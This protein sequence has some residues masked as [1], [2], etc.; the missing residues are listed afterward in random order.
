VHNVFGRRLVAIVAL[1]VLVLGAYAV[2]KFNVAKGLSWSVSFSTDASLI[3]AI[4]LAAIVPARKMVSWARGA[5]PLSGTTLDQAR[6]DLARTLASSWAEEE[7]LRRINDPWPLPVR[8][9]GPEA[10]QFSEI[11]QFFIGAASR[12]LVILGEAGAGKTALAIKLVLE[13]L[14]T[15]EAGDPVPVLLA[16]ATWTDSVAMT[17]W[18]ARQLAFDHPGLAVTIRTGIGETVSLAHSLASEVLPVID[19]LDELPE[20]RRAQVI[21]EIN[22][23]G[24][25]RSVVLTSRPAE[26]R[27]AIASREVTLATT[28]SLDS[29]EVSQV[30]DYLTAATEAPQD[31]WYPVFGA[32]DADPRGSLALALTNPLMLWLARTVYEHGDTQPAELTGLADRAAVEGHLL[33]GFVPAAY[34]RRSGA[35]GFRCAPAQAQRWLG[36]LAA[37]LNQASSPDI[38]WWRLCL[39]EPG[40][41]ALSLAI[42]ST[43]YACVAWWAITLAL[44]RRGYWH[45]GVQSF[46]GQFREL[47]LAGPLGRSVLSLTGGVARSLPPGFDANVNTFLGYIESFGLVRI[48]V[49]VFLVALL[50]GIV[51]QTPDPQTA[52]MTFRIFRTEVLWEWVAAWLLAYA[53]WGSQAQREPLQDIAPQWRTK[54]VL[55]CFGILTVRRIL[56]SLA[57]PVD[58]SSAPEPVGLLRQTRRV[59]LL[60]C[61][62]E[63]ADVA[64]VWLW[65]GTTLAV[66]FAIVKVTR[67]VAVPESDDG[68]AWPRYL[69]AKCRLSIRRRLPWRTTSFLEDAH[70]RGVLR[71][72]GAAY[73]FR[74]IRLQE[75]LAQGYSPWPPLLAPA[76]AQ[77]HTAV[78]TT[79]ALVQEKASTWRTSSPAVTT[80]AN[81]V[82]G[83]IPAVSARDVAREQLLASAPWVAG[84]LTLAVLAA[85]GSWYLCCAGLL[86]T[87]GL[88]LV[89]V[90][91]Q[92]RRHK[93]GAGIVPGTWSLRPADGGV[94]VTRDGATVLVKTSDIERVSV[95]RVRSADGSATKWTALHARLHKG[96]TLPFAARKRSLPLVWL[97]TR[98]VSGGARS[99]PQL[100]T[101]I[102]WFPKEVLDAELAN[103]KRVTARE[104][105]ISGVIQPPSIPWT[106]A[107]LPAFAV[108]LALFVFSQRD[109]GFV[110]LVG[111]LVMVGICVYRLSERAA[112]HEL[113]PGPWSLRVTPDGI[114]IEQ[115]GTATHL[116]PDDILE[117]DLRILRGE[118]GKDTILSAVQVRLRPGAPAVSLTRDGWL[119]VYPKPMASSSRTPTELVAALHGLVGP[120]L[121]P[122][123]TRL[124]KSAEVIQD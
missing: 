109:L 121:G 83:V 74:H 72:V 98:Q 116:A 1:V 3:L 115:N 19:G 96:A 21:A 52:R 82:S 42:R 87:G 64:I 99:S 41:S 119:P 7:R 94:L 54:L 66:A 25:A 57:V 12:R 85:I 8:W 15:R 86:L 97:W 60:G 105:T 117:A 59:F 47:L 88:L 40:W 33:A 100:L 37:W 118:K 38:A 20:T 44:V 23:Q 113:P 81:T 112:V 62:A 103:L 32:L 9:S 16:A 27:A 120:R 90:W 5:P 29:L 107:V 67:L 24:S 36:F 56:S 93:A 58:V 101:S 80:E 65:V 92:L 95:S 114:D 11:G 104:Y 63:A 79:T 26:Y 50:V 75:Q 73:Q 53:W 49:V 61:L 91:V 14:S 71:Q 43:V 34:A 6:E 76:A 2:V 13:L 77:I 17:E 106:E 28:I 18:I 68:G 45:S 4:I 39:A 110:C 22:A 108:S 31:R 78:E 10:G 124:A 30:R 51:P 55:I 35:R 69:Y 48:A 122:R 46:H 84:G 70:R 102:R 111:S 123:L 89:S